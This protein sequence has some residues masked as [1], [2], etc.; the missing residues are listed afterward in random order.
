MTWLAIWLLGVGVT[1]LA[2]SLGAPVRVAAPCGIALIGLLTALGDITAAHELVILSIGA[3][4]LVAWVVLA[5]RAEDAGRGHRRALGVLAVGVLGSIAFS[6]WPSGVGGP[7]AD[8][9]QSMRLPM[10][11]LYN[12]GGSAGVTLLALALMLVNLSTANVVVRL[13]L[14]SI[15]AIRPT[16]PTRVD[17][18]ALAAPAAPAGP[19]SGAAAELRGGRLLGPMERVLI[20][21]LGLAGELTAAGLVIGA[22]GLIRFPELQAKRSDTEEVSGVGID[23]VTEYFLVGSFVSW[24]IALGSLALLSQ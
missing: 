22:K 3:V 5:H 1:D 23:A 2:R 14:V 7:L 13:V 19:A 12:P 18:A 24:L 6:G 15:G 21:G 11:S 8:W 16:D 20:L 10:V 4:L 9:L 17:P